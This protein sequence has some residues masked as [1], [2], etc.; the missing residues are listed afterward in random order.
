MPDGQISQTEA[1]L[2]WTAAA[3]VF[4]QHEPCSIFLA[5]ECLSAGGCRSRGPMLCGQFTR[6]S[7]SPPSP[8]GARRTSAARV[9]D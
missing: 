2:L 5:G 1:R 4:T 7:K 6:A 8:V 9:E 3:L